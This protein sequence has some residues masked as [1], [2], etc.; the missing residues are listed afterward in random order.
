MLEGIIHLGID[1]EDHGTIS[2][3]ARGNQLQHKV[4]NID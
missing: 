4:E 2:A 3:G 1:V